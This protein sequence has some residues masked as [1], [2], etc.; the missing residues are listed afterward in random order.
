MDSGYGNPA[1]VTLLLDRGAESDINAENERGTTPLHYAAYLNSNPEVATLL[2]QRGADI[3]ARDNAGKTPC[4]LARS[5]GKFTGH[6]VQDVLCA[7]KSL[8]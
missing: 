7:P 8:S 1:V 2:I 4:Q 3:H 5:R 6:P